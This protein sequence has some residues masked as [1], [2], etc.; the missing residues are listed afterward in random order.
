MKKA[1]KS[2]NM[3]SI[4]HFPTH[5][6]F[7]KDDVPLKHGEAQ[8]SEEAEDAGERFHKT[9]ISSA[10][11]D[12]YPPDL[13]QEKPGSGLKCELLSSMALKRIATAGLAALSLFGAIA[14]QPL[15]AQAQEPPVSPQVTHERVIDAD[16]PRPD[17]GAKS[18][19]SGAEAQGSTVKA[20]VTEKSYDSEFAE[21][22]AKNARAVAK[23][24]ERSG[25][26]GKCFRGVKRALSKF[27]ILLTGKFARLAAD[28]LAKLPNMKEIAVDR[29]DLN[30][31]KPGSIVVWSKGK[32]HPYGHISIA[33]GDGD[34]AS[35]HI[36]GQ[37][38]NLSKGSTFR[39]FIPV[40]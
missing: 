35:D 22:L 19:T 23:K 20:Q 26:D 36:Q 33:L 10:I 8:L 37:I 3:D 13:L 5:L 12:I 32:D 21:S 29:S 17:A 34:E 1:G 38:T 16:L 39:V 24:M 25:S 31:L 6:N 2:D 4:K 27:R 15:Y 18:P 11:Q 14:A 30:D 28:Q 9:L 7:T 40:H